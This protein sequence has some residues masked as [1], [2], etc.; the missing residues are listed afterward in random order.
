MN[1]SLP[2]TSYR[3]KNTVLRKNLIGLRPIYSSPNG[4][5]AHGSEG[6]GKFKSVFGIA[7]E[8]QEPWSMLKR[9][10]FPQLLNDPRIRGMASDI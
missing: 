10:R 1:L 8:N 5:D 6:Y 4:S 2:K 7:V 3:L 9:E